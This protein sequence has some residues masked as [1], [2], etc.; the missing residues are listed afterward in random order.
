MND[1]GEY[2][3]EIFQRYKDKLSQVCSILDK[4]LENSE[5]LAGEYS[6]ADIAIFPWTVTFEDMA[7]VDLHDFPYLQRWFMKINNRKA[8][9]QTT[10]SELAQSEWCY[11]N[12][13]IALCGTN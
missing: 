2:P 3:E 5:Y 9:Q 6:V 8:A 13:K 10:S 1:S 11:L 12:G 7:E 4:E